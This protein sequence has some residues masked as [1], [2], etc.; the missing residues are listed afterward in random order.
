MPKQRPQIFSREFKLTALARLE[1]GEKVGAVARELSVSHQVLYRWRAQMR[2]GGAGAL[3]PLGR[4]R[5]D[6]IP[7]ATPCPAASPEEL[8]LTAAQARIADL[9]RKVGRQQ[10]EL[11]FFKRA[12]RQVEALRRPSE[13]GATAST[14]SSKR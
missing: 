12:L 11:D 4:P 6:A 13:P 10:L 14:P 2:A 9:E 5:K 7:P 3:R 1:A 8:A